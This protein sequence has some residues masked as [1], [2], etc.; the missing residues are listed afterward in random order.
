MGSRWGWV[1]GAGLLGV[2]CAVPLRPYHQALVT[3]QP[4][5]R[6]LV[7]GGDV[8]RERAGLQLARRLNLPLVVSGGS[9]PNMP[10]G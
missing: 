3:A 2:V 1:A 8:D 4:P 6:I 10:T 5:E 9:I 7:L